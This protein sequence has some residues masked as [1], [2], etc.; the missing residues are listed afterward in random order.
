MAMAR[1]LHQWSEERSGITWI[2][3]LVRAATVRRKSKNNKDFTKEVNAARAVSATR[4]L[5]KAPRASPS[6]AILPASGI[7][8]RP[9]SSR[10]GHCSVNKQGIALL[11]RQSFAP[12]PP[13]PSDDVS[14]MILVN[15]MISGTCNSGPVRIRFPTWIQP[16]ELSHPGSG[17]APNQRFAEPPSRL[18]MVSPSFPR[19][20][21]RRGRLALLTR[22]GRLAAPNSASQQDIFVF[23][24]SPVP[25]RASWRR[26]L[27]VAASCAL[28]PSQSPRAT[29]QS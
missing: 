11:E 16:R 6:C 14:K 3:R 17:A 20:M 7:G 15:I 26:G 1:C 19:R 18:L 13:P 10:A 2:F 22:T 28:V 23:S 8:R 12:V 24:P 25:R 21:T 27:A 9:D 29:G 4:R 5:A